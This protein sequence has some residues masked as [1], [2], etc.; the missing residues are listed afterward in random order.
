MKKSSSKYIIAGT[1]KYW[2]KYRK[3]AIST[4]R[5]ATSRWR[6]LPDFIIIGAQKGG[7]T[8]LFYYLN[9]HPELALARRKEVYFFNLN[10]EKGINWYKSFFP[11]RSN[12]KISGEA[13]PSYLF[14]PKTAKRIKSALPDVKLIVLLRNPIDRAYSGYAMGLKRNTEQNTFEVAIEQE[15][16]ALEKHNDP[17]NYSHERHNQ[18]YLERGKYYSQLRPW[19][20]EFK[21]E[22]FLFIKSE[23]FFHDPKNELEK[24]YEFLEISTIFPDDLSQRN[25]GKYDKISP[26]TVKRL[27]DYF[28]KENEQLVVLLGK[29]FQWKQSIVDGR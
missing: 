8:S 25:P 7:T 12:K 18:F 9:Q 17:N 1:K 24:V 10:Y 16:A 6:K 21:R 3:K 5:M 15:L 4:Y 26:N 28:E 14:Y 11:F 2:R 23:N 27:E 19:L 20:E 22:Q 13:T 29:E